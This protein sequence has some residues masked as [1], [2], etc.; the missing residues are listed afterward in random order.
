[1]RWFLDTEFH[2]D[3]RVIDL[4]SIALVNENGG[5]Y[6]AVSTEFDPEKCGE[7]VKANVLPKL[8]LRSSVLWKPRTRI[9]DDIRTML[10]YDDDKPEIWAYF[11]DYDWVALCQLYGRMID[12]PKGFPF[13]CRDLKQLMA[14]HDVDKK[15]LPAEDPNGEHNAL[16]DA[17]WVRA[18]Y[19]HIGCTM[20]PRRL[21]RNR[22]T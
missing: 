1:M 17:R 22:R 9:A 16:A 18:A 15:D 7:W 3:G 2:E 14:D 11:A 19:L 4:I 8:P 5:F 20:G 21:M 6:Y 10:L 12:L 13:W